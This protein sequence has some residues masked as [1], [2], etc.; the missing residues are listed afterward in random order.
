[1]KVLARA[2]GH[3]HLSEFALRDLT[4]LELRHCEA[5]G[6]SLRRRR[7]PMSW[8]AVGSVLPSE[9][10]GARLELHWAAQ[11]ASAPGTSWLAPAAD[12]G[13]TTLRW[14]SALGVL[15]GRTLARTSLRAALV[16]EALELAVVDVDT[17]RVSFQ[18]AGA[19]L[20]EA[21]EWLR[22]QMNPE[23][24][25][26]ELPA[27]DMPSHPVVDGVPFSEGGSQA[28]TEL[29]AWFSN[30]T[31]AIHGAVADEAG[32]SLVRCCPIISTWRAWLRS[33][34]TRTPRLLAASASAFRPAT[35]PMRAVFLREPLAL[36]IGRRASIARKRRCALAH[37]WLDGCGVHSEP[38]PFRGSGASRRVRDDR[39]P[40]SD[41]GKSRSARWLA[42]EQE[43]ADAGGDRKHLRP[44]G[45]GGALVFVCPI[46]C[47]DVKK[48]AT[49][50]GFDPR[51]TPGPIAER[52]L[53]RQDATP[54]APMSARPAARRM[55]L[56]ARVPR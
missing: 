26:L 7:E 29:A 25:R 24:E 56:C 4:D 37:R 27:H 9:L 45:Q 33:T 12:F 50:R 38:D 5:G 15:A 51:F 42:P 19:T 55:P 3:P 22:Q 54:R 40:R 34:P 43:H 21:L 52:C 14:D 10:T 30:A 44:T 13:H 23:A 31:W 36:S 6:G 41:R 46:V 17:E 20:A 8:R 16:F 11:L 32:A 2:C 28:R 48:E 39:A 47:D 35:A 1:M 18:L 49:H 53:L